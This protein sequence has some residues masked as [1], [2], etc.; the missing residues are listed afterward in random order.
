MLFL[1][2]NGIGES[3]SPAE[4]ISE[5]FFQNPAKKAHL[6]APT[7]IFPITWKAE[8]ITKSQSL[9]LKS[10]NNILDPH[11]D[12]VIKL[13]NLLQL[14]ES[15][16]VRT[17]HLVQYLLQVQFSGLTGVTHFSGLESLVAYFTGF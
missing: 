15:I 3:S 13:A 14:R 5:E 6:N 1:K 10:V 12:A 2:R 16:L 8:N 17:A 11:I 4:Q 7:K 9:R